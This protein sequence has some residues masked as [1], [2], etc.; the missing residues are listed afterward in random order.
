MALNLLRA[1]APQLRG[2]RSPLPYLVLGCL[3]LGFGCSKPEPPP[4][5]ISEAQKKFEQK[6]RDEFGLH[7][8]TRQVGQTLWIYRPTKES[9]F[10]YEAQKE[11]AADA[12]KKPS[13][14]MVQYL[15]GEFKDG[16]FSFEYDIV[17][18]KKSK[19][20]N[21][22]YTGTYTDSYIKEQNNIFTAIYDVF[23]NAEAKKRATTKSVL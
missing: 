5:S 10:D 23:F 18:R 13:K 22:G 1:S 3:A 15:D 19:Q 11:N 4:I 16:G 7:V 12:Q 2:V 6:C 14:F 20:E 21:F 8:I 17:D 9:I